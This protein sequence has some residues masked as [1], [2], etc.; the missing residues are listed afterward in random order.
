L[1]CSLQTIAR[2]ALLCE[3]LA[4]VNQNFLAVC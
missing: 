4:V 2:S 1:A 3:R